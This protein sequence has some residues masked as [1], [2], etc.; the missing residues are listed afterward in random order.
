MEKDRSFEVQNK[1]SKSLGKVYSCISLGEYHLYSEVFGISVM[2]A[3]NKI[4]QLLLT[5]FKKADKIIGGT[6]NYMYLNR[7]Q[8]YKLPKFIAE[9]YSSS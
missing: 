7:G 3:E 6:I 9:A 4:Q 2:E 1:E 5:D 8:V